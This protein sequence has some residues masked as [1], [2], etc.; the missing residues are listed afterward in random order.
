MVHRRK[1]S[2]TAAVLSE[3]RTP[4]PILSRVGANTCEYL[5]LNCYVS[6]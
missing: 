5:L 6:L 4:F 1:L 3:I 2:F